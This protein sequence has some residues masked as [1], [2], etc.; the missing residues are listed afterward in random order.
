MG[1]HLGRQTTKSFHYKEEQDPI[2]TEQERRTRPPPLALPTDGSHTSE[3]VV[4]GELVQARE[5]LALQRREAAEPLD[6][7]HGYY[8]RRMQTPLGS[9]RPSAPDA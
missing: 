6:N 9:E 5:M 4:V 7:V 1:Q 3:A 8:E 2:S